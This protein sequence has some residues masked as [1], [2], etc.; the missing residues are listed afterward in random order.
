M[1][2]GKPLVNLSL[3][4]SSEIDVTDA[5]WALKSDYAGPPPHASANIFMVVSFRQN[6]AKANS[7]ETV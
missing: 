6:E 3:I 4:V 7:R 2:W 1:L 5:C